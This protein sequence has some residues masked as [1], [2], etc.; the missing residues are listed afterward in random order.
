M[1][2]PSFLVVGGITFGLSLSLATAVFAHHSFT[3]E[4]DATK[5]V[6]L[7]GTIVKMEWINPHSWLHINVTEPDGKVVEWALEFGNPNQLLHQGWRKGD[8]PVGATVTVDGFR[9]RNGSPT[10]NARTVLLANGKQLFTGGSKP[11]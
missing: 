2:K 1:K 9:A 4:Y 3:S 8:L 5:K 6:S 11:D 7:K 10:A